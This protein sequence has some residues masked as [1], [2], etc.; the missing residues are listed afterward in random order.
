[1][2]IRHRTR[3]RRIAVTV[4]ALLLASRAASAQTRQPLTLAALLDSVARHPIVEAAQAHVRAAQGSRVASGAFGNPVFS[5]LVD[6]TPFPGGSSVRG[7][8]REGMTTL[9]VPL[10][11]VYQRGARVRMADAQL[12]GA[13]NDAFATRQRVALDASQ[14]YCRTAVAQLGVGTSRDLLAWLDS[15]VTYNHSRVEEGAAAE[16]DL[17]RSQLERDRAAIDVTMQEADL[18]AARAALSSFLGDPRMVDM[19]LLI[20]AIDELPLPMPPASLAGTGANRPELLAARER[21]AAAN[22]GTSIERSMILRQLGATIGTK[23]TAGTTSMIAGLSLPIPLFDP[24]RGEMARANAERDV[25]AFY[26]AAAERET[27]AGVSGA[28]EAAAVLTDRANALAQA[29]TQGGRPALLARADDARRIALGAYREGAVP[30][31]QV[32]DA[33]RAS[34]DARLAYYRLIYTQR[35]SV[36]KLIVARG[37]DIVKTL[38]TIPSR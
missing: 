10:E 35:E 31:I 29:L 6:N 38:K 1:M 8:E 11:P 30:L 20:V 2:S 33:A 34:A 32:L 13:M 28:S 21:L 17:I 3:G 5:Y 26:L 27:T 15:V 23:Q 36:L 24:N 18:A 12:R 25:A 9:T 22:A 19:R 4:V 7:I 16:A 37:D 14:A